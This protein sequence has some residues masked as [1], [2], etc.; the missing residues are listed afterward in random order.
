MIVCAPNGFLGQSIGIYEKKHFYFVLVCSLKTVD[1]TVLGGLLAFEWL[2][3]HAESNLRC[4]KDSR[5]YSP[6]LLARQA[7]RR[8]LLD[9]LGCYILFD[10]S[11]V[12]FLLYE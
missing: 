11:S 1:A 7:D 6:E 10:E 2:W 12:P 5:T 9:R 4:S 3:H 8:T